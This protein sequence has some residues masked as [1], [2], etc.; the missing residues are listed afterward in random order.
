V[1]L[2]RTVVVTTHMLLASLLAIL[3]IIGLFARP[4]DGAALGVALIGGFPVSLFIVLP[5]SGIV[6]FGLLDWQMGRGPTILRAADAF[7]FLLATLELSVGVA[8]AARWLIGTMAILAAV[9]VAASIVVA[10]PRRPGF[11]R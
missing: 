6:A 4:V 2:G 7:A 9:G 10:A 5:M 8:G 11:R 3:A 1:E